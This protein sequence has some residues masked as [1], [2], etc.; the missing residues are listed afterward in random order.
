METNEF[1][2]NGFIKDT[3]ITVNNPFLKIVEKDDGESW[4]ISFYIK[5]L[6]IDTIELE[7]PSIII[8]PAVKYLPVFDK[9]DNI[10]GNV[11]DRIRNA[12]NLNNT[13][14]YFINPTLKRIT[15]TVDEAEV[16]YSPIVLDDDN[17]ARAVANFL[18]YELLLY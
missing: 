15:N 17:H 6:L 16:G 2:K 7:C 3:D 13:S 4:T 11:E 14:M 12:M 10:I 5:D 9:D 18:N 1:I 8:H